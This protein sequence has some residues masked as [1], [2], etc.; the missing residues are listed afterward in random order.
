MIKH[1]AS[2]SLAY[3]F[4]TIASAMFIAVLH[5][6]VPG[7]VGWLDA[8]ASRLIQLLGLTMVS[9]QEIENMLLAS[10]LCF[11]WGI[12]FKRLNSRED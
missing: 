3:A 8:L 12:G 7:L 10:L 4:S 5:S 9:Q 1:G 2:H 6:L 11:L